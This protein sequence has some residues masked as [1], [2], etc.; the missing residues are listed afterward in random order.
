M[1]YHLD[2]IPVW[3]AYHEEGECPLCILEDKS[4]KSYVDSFLGGSVT[5]FLPAF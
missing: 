2:T 4:E 3:D 5:A 1:K